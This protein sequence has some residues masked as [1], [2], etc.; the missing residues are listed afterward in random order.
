MFESKVTA[1]VHI[2]SFKDKKTFKEVDMVY[3]TWYKMFY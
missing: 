1:V 3:E 2:E